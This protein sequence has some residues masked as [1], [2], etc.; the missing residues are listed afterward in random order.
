MHEERRDFARSAMTYIRDNFPDV[1]AMLPERLHPF[2]YGYRIGDGMAT[3]PERVHPAWL[4][5]GGFRPFVSAKVPED[6]F[7]IALHNAGSAEYLAIMARAGHRR[8]WFYDCYVS[9]DT[10]RTRTAARSRESLGAT[11]ARWCEPFQR[12]IYD[13]TEGGVIR[14]SALRKAPTLH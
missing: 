14:G 11:L 4:C 3:H 8:L 2:S 5:S 9:F 6:F 7:V 12:V 13:C 10:Q 1:R